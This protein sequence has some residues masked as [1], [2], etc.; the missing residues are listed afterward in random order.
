MR[1]TERIGYKG[2]CGCCPIMST[3][4]STAI[5]RYRQFCRNP[6]PMS[7]FCAMVAD[8]KHLYLHHHTLPTLPFGYIPPEDPLHS[9]V[10]LLVILTTS[11]WI[12]S[13]T[14]H[15]PDPE[16]D[17]SVDMFLHPLVSDLF[18][19]YQY[20]YCLFCFFFL[21]LTFFFP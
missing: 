17:W 10:G 1:S 5:A 16:F 9:I 7:I 6:R 4:V 19:R 18:L 13:T 21:S 20:V 3:S 2:G 15:G 11:D 12:L 14:G 8:I